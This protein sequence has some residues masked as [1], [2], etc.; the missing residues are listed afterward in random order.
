MAT[1]TEADLQRVG[2]G[3]GNIRES[4][5]I[6]A[7]MPHQFLTLKYILG[8]R[9]DADEGVRSFRKLYSQD[10][11]LGSGSCAKVYAGKRR[12]DELLVAIKMPR[13]GANFQ[14]IIPEVGHTMRSL[15]VTRT[16]HTHA[17][18]FSTHV[19]T[20]IAGLMQAHV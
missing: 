12:R 8:L 11:E 7:P 4:M 5:G 16:A 14:Q 20:R 2:E 19:H 17:R 15:F 10:T 9:L 1:Q 18:G 3:A 6:L 13:D